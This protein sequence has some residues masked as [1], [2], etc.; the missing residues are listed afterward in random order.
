MNITTAVIEDSSGA[1]KVTWFNQPYIETQ[2]PVG[3][4][5]SLAGKVT[6]GKNGIYISSPTYEK[7]RPLTTDYDLRSPDLKHTTGLVPIYPETEGITS[8]YLRFL[9]KPL[10]SKI[11]IADPLPPEILAKYNFIPV[12]EALRTIHYPSNL[13]EANKTKERFA[14]DELLLFQIK[15]LLER[16]KLNQLKSVSIKFDEN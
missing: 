12:E 7:I 1:I 5:V 10:L 11:N 14:F 13:D 16:R 2:L 9:I 15:S 4:L 3:S 8:K 6:N